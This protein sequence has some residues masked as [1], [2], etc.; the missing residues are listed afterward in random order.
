MSLTL[1]AALFGAFLVGLG[2]GPATP[3]TIYVDPPLVTGLFSADSFE[4]NIWI[5]GGEAVYAWEF[6]M[7]YPGFAERISVVDVVEGPYLESAEVMP[8]GTYMAKYVNAFEGRVS[9]TGT[10]LGDSYGAYGD[11]ILATVRFTII[12]PAGEFPLDLF[13]ARIWTRF[14]S[15]IFEIPAE[16]ITLVDGYFLGPT[17]NLYSNPGEARMD[18]VWSV[19]KPRRFK[20]IVVNTGYDDIWARAKYR[21]VSDTGRV[22][23][24]YSG[25][26][27]YTTQPRATEYFYVNEFTATRLSWIETGTSPYLDVADGTSYVTGETYCTTS[28]M[29]GFQDITMNPGDIIYRVTLEART[30]SAHK[31][32]DYDVYDASFN[33]Y[34]SLWGTGA[35]TWRGIRWVTDTIDIINPAVKTQAGFNSFQLLLHYYSPD[36]SPMGPADLDAM[37]LKVEFIGLDPLYAGGVHIQPDTQRTLDWAV[38]DLWPF[39]VGTWT[40]TVTVEYRWGTPDRRFP[41]FWAKGPTVATFTWT[42]HP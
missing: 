2:H 34:G 6:G 39:D 36:G 41:Q 33:W 30:R 38:W 40:T 28:G 13:Y 37:R 32:I 31:D 11:G 42:V 23:T 3:I 15:E 27:M 4:L 21:S 25:Q 14:D 19:G 24:L 10:L 5:T 29:Y 17:L 7:N 18:N 12:E 26:H 1:I 9:A 16:D 22:V 8:D 35:W 20:S